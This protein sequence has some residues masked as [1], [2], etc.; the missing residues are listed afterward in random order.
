MEDDPYRSSGQDGACPRCNNVLVGDGGLTCP[1]GCGD[2][3]SRDELAAHWSW[4]AARSAE[5]RWPQRPAP[6]PICKR[7]MH[8]ASREELRFD[9]CDAHG[10]WLD[11]GELA[12][13]LELV[14]AAVPPRRVELPTLSMAEV[15]CER[16]LLDLIRSAS[17]GQ[18]G[19]ETA[20]IV[21]SAPERVSLVLHSTE[22][23]PVTGLDGHVLVIKA[24]EDHR[25]VLRSPDV[26]R[27]VAVLRRRCANAIFRAG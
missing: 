9:R 19:A 2:W 5:M 12:R 24:G 26:P 22:H 15:E 8:V 6:C 10:V 4:I 13:F 14:H 25:I 21:E 27:F 16:Q 11:T 1:A 20:W 3:R 18:R 17:V 23:D 7:E